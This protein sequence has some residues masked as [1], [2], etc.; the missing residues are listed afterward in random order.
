MNHERRC[1]VTYSGEDGDRITVEQCEEC[2]GV[3][4]TKRLRLDDGGFGPPT[5]I[6]IPLNVFRQIAADT[7]DWEA[8]VDDDEEGGRQ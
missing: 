5:T 6:D 4:I 1:S 8:I 7:K 2:G 3:V